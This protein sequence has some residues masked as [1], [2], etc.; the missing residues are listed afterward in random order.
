M[1]SSFLDIKEG[2]IMRIIPINNSIPQAYTFKGSVDNSVSDF[3]T[4]TAEDEAAKKSKYAEVDNTN[5]IK[6]ADVVIEDL[7]GY[8]SNLHP[9]TVLRMRDNNSDNVVMYN[10]LLD[11]TIQILPKSRVWD[12]TPIRYRIELDPYWLSRYRVSSCKDF[13]DK[14]RQHSPQDIDQLFI[15]KSIENLSRKVQDHYKNNLKNPEQKAEIDKQIDKI[16]KYQ[17]D[18]SL[19]LYTREEI[20]KRVCAV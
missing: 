1:F 14:L 4:K 8:M 2:Q 10:S 18:V 3:I 16:L 6:N 9:D 11:T 7:K 20:Q 12:N 15:G 19:N 5:Y 13:S 17:K